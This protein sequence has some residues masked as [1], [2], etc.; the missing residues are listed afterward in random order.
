MSVDCHGCARARP[1]Q[2]PP[3][4]LHFEC[5]ASEDASVLLACLDGLRENGS[6]L[7]PFEVVRHRDAV[8]AWPLLFEPRA[9][10]RCAG[11]TPREEPR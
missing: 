4:A 3:D 9:L 11:F 1:K 8:T 7:L 10:A 6:C 5:K 2:G